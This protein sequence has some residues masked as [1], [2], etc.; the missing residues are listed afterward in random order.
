MWYIYTM[1]YYSSIKNKDLWNSYANDESR[2][3]HPE[4]G[5]PITKEH[6]CFFIYNYLEK[7]YNEN[8]YQPQ[9]HVQCS[10]VTAGHWMERQG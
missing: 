2:G 4:W 3:D 6:T 10:I 7:T 5:N 8:P 9:S 1:E